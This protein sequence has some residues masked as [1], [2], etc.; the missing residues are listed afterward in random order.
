MKI[1]GSTVLVTGEEAL[2]GD[3]GVLYPMLAAS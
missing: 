3:V 2:A 1:E